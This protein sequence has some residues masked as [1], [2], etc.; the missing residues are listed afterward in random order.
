MAEIDFKEESGILAGEVRRRAK[1]RGLDPKALSVEQFI[2]LEA[3]IFSEKKGNNEMKSEKFDEKSVEID[4]AIQQL[5]IEKGVDLSDDPNGS[6]YADLFLEVAE[7]EDAKTPWDPLSKQI[8]QG[9]TQIARDRGLDG[10]DPVVYE[11]I[12]LEKFSQFAKR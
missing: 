4:A 5:A 11:K 6:K 9:V 2:E 1:F 10:S 7:G 3:E 8:H 12:Y